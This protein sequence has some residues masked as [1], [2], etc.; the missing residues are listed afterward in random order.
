VHDELAV[1]FAL[2]Q[3]VERHPG[4][5]APLHRWVRE[6][7]RT[8]IDPNGAPMQSGEQPGVLWLRSLL[9]KLTPADVAALRPELEALTA[10]GSPVAAQARR[11]LDDAR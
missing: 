10:A 5:R 7:L 6:R 2:Q 3:A 1:L 4:E 11:L 8:P 9:Q